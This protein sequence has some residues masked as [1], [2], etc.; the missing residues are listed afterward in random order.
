MASRGVSAF[1]NART[2]FEISRSGLDVEPVSYCGK[3]KLVW[4]R[5]TR[6][7]GDTR[8]EM[9]ISTVRLEEVGNT[10]SILDSKVYPVLRN[11]NGVLNSRTK[12][13]YREL[14]L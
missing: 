2:V 12:I 1:H 5:R 9:A 3:E 4:I 6:L 8:G 10:E 14:S 7:G 13:V 11:V